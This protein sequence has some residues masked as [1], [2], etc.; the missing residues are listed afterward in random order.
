M[1]SVKHSV[2]LFELLYTRHLTQPH[3]Y[4]RSRSILAERQ[5]IKGRRTESYKETQVTRKN[6]L[7][8]RTL[9]TS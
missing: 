1:V 8:E 5:V 2:P 9:F 6:R 3:C 4:A 7:F